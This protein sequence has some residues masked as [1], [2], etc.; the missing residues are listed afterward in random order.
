MANLEYSTLIMIHTNSI[1][2]VFVSSNKNKIHDFELIAKELSDKFGIEITVKSFQPEVDVEEN[3]SSTIENAL[4]KLDNAVK[5]FKGDEI[6]FTED[7]AFYISGLDYK[8]GILAHR[9]GGDDP[10]GKVLKTIPKNSIDHY[11]YYECSIA[12]KNLKGETKQAVGQT[13]GYIANEKRGSLSFGYDQIFVDN[14]VADL[15]AKTVSELSEIQPDKSFHFHRIDAFSK[16]I[17]QLLED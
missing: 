5:E 9:W 10:C 13:H 14:H 1:N 8:P 16:M 7:T 11:A 15:R 6:I 17:K 2:F 3:G 4:I 12:Y